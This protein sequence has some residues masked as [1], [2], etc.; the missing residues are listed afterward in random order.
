[1]L[2]FL[3]KY[4][5]YFL[6]I[7]SLLFLLLVIYEFSNSYD[8]KKYSIYFFLSFILIIFSI[9]TF[10][11]KNN[12]LDYLIISIISIF[13]TFYSFEFLLTNNF[14]KNKDKNNYLLNNELTKYDD[15]NRFEIYT[16]LL[17]SNKEIKV[18]VTPRAYVNN[19][20]KKLN[21]RPLS[22]ISNSKTIYC[23][24]NG[25]YSFFQSD[26][27]GFNNPDNEWDK[28]DIEYLLIGDSFTLGGCVNAPHDIASVLRI[29]SNKNIL[30]L[31]YGGNGPLLEYA[32]LREYLDQKVKNVIMIYYEGND[33]KN[34]QTELKDEFL[35]QYLL[36]SNYS[37]QLKFQQKLIDSLAHEMI[38]VEMKRIIEISQTHK[39][40][41][42]L[43]KM[44]KFIKLSNIRFLIKEKYF[45]DPNNDKNFLNKDFEMVMKEIKRTVLENKSKL[46]FVYLPEWSR[47]KYP[48]S[49]SNENY[50][51][52]REIIKNLDIKFI[53]I[54]KVFL[55]DE[56]PLSLFPFRMHGHYNIEG[57]LKVSKTIYDEILKDQL[58]E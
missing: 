48:I 7:L 39:I 22:G 4:F 2:F 32:A 23:N 21:I 10:F 51:K 55:E 47:F 24:E 41:F 49:Y 45:Y 6:F 29:L 31:G 1:M 46:Y 3:R 12:F 42:L 40:Y 9:C 25:Y 38:D 52:I 33:L 57:Y 44:L 20:N 26:R 56:D 36:N 37:Q 50:N 43:E 34:L 15:R 5:S 19:I 13:I 53:D 18:T 30:N 27:Y 35:N 14:F 54:K 17:K 28:T 8:L 58:S 16:D 11:L